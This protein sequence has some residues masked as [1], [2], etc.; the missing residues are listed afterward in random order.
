MTLKAKSY[1]LQANQGST[2]I[3]L[4][5]YLAIVSVL[6]TSLILWSLTV[7]NLGARAESGAELNASGRFA[8]EIITRDIEQATTVITPASS[9]PSPVLTLTDA[10]SETVT[11]SV[12]SDELIRTVAGGS[13]LPLT[14]FPATVVDFNV[15]RATG[16]WAARG[17]L[18]VTLT[19]RAFSSSPRTFITAV[20]L[21]R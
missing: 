2:L 10:L 20:S 19:L 13:A 7:G 4:I 3:E 14:T 17:S 6:A 5:I 16:P 11:I 21:R 18:V 12:T 1:K 9:V 8:L 15:A